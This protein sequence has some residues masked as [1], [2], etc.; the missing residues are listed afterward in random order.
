MSDISNNFE[1]VMR[2][3]LDGA[4]GMLTSKTVVGSPIT[5][6]DTM[7]IPLSDVTIGCAAGSNNGNKKDGGAG[8]FSAKVSPTAVLIIKGGNTKVVNIKDSNS[9]TRL[10][11]MVPEVVDK[12]IA[13]RQAEDMM[14]D[15]EAVDLAFEKEDEK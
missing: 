8:G 13:G 9:V 2:S 6:G 7:L 10:I 15:E 12:F 1:N 14:S 5:V 11:D 3:L 4:N